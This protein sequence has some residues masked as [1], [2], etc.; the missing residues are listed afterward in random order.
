MSEHNDSR[1]MDLCVLVIKIVFVINYLILAW[2][3][4]KEMTIIL[5]LAIVSAAFLT[6]FELA[7]VVLFVLGIVGAAKWVMQLIR[8]HFCKCCRDKP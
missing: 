7:I 1:K 4:V 8:K 3:L 2:M 6:F 5:V